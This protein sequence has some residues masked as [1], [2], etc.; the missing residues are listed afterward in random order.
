VRTLTDPVTVRHIAAL[1]E[2]LPFEGNDNGL[3]F[4]CPNA[5]ATN[6]VDWFTFRATPQGPVL[7]KLTE[8]ATTGPYPD[9]CDD[10]TLTIRGHDDPPIA[11]GGQL[12]TEVDRLLGVRLT[13][14]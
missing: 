4:S 3:A 9:P 11:G 7:A 14:R 13:A 12:L 2:A 5:L 1:I 10:P 6:P 8:A